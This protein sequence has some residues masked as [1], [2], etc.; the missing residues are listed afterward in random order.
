MLNFLFVYRA[1]VLGCADKIE[2]F[3]EVKEEEW[4][5]KE[6]FTLQTDSTRNVQYAVVYVKM[7]S[8]GATDDEA[9]IRLLDNRK[10]NRKML[11]IKFSKRSG[12][13]SICESSR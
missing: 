12:R 8:A 13:I 6:T 2:L 9:F 7:A 4:V 5:P 3:D 1:S 10:S 11:T